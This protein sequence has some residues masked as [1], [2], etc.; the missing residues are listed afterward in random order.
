MIQASTVEEALTIL[1]HNAL[2]LVLVDERVEG[3]RAADVCR[4]L[5][6]GEHNRDVPILLLG[7]SDTS[8]QLDTYAAGADGLIAVAA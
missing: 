5:R 4:T 2:D 1:E 7:S 3:T 6:T 8:E